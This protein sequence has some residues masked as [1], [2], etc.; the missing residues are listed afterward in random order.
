MRGGKVDSR[1]PRGDT[2][3]FLVERWRKLRS[4][5]KE[6]GAQFFEVHQ[7]QTVVAARVLPDSSTVQASP[8]IDRKDGQEKVRKVLRL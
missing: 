8:H 1:K 5:L 7:W 6:Q 3:G 2:A 4:G